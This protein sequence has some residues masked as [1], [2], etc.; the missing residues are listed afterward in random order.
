MRDYFSRLI[1]AFL[2][3]ATSVAPAAFTD[4][5]YVDDAESGSGKHFSPLARTRG[6]IA[7]NLHSNGS[8]WDGGPRS[9]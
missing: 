8:R 3:S 6:S 4:R 1:T 7:I 9:T 5:A 2:L